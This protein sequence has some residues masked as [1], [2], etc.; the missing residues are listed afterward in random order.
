MRIS[1]YSNTS[2]KNVPPQARSIILIFFGIIILIVGSFSQISYNIKKE[3]F[4]PIFCSVIGY[5]TETKVVKDDDG[6]EYE[7]YTYCPEYEYVIGDEVY[8]AKLDEYS[9]I[10]PTLG[11][12]KKMWY[13]PKKS[14]DVIV[15]TNIYIIIIIFG[16]VVTI[17]GIISSIITFKKF[18]ETL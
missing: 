6:N 3:T 13:N 17:L 16:T 4:V 2:A 10:K 12:E 5:D 7:E 9:S 11:T 14:N 8:T 18:N 1:L 15:E